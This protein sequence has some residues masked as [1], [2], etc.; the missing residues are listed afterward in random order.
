[1]HNYISTFL[2]QSLDRWTISYRGYHPYNSQCFDTDM[3]Y[4]MYY[5]IM[6]LL[7]NLRPISHGNRHDQ[8][9]KADLG[10]PVQALLFRLSC[11]GYPVQAILFRL[12]CFGYPVQALLFRLSCLAILFRLS[13]LGYPVLAILLRLSCLGYLVQA[14]CSQRLLCQLAFLCLDYDRT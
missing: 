13:C 10:Y 4:Q 1:M 6:L 9:I 14:L 2:L 12:S 8:L 3:V 5:Y 7:L 11:F